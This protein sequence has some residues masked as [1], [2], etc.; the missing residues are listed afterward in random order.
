MSRAFGEVNEAGKEE[1]SN[2]VCLSTVPLHQYASKRGQRGRLALY[3]IE[4]CKT[5]VA[6]GVAPR[7]ANIK[8]SPNGRQRIYGP[9]KMLF[10]T[11]GYLWP[12]VTDDNLP[13]MMGRYI[14]PRVRLRGRSY[15]C[16]S[17]NSWGPGGWLA[18]VFLGTKQKGV[19]STN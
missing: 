5:I 7:I 15:P 13:L 19:V 16:C 12:L 4:K 18:D 11:V 17:G 8:D 3:L 1:R 2:K 9:T 10:R 14:G 6:E